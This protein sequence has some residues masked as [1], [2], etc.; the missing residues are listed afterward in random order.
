MFIEYV[1]KYIINQN[2]KNTKNK[3]DE[4]ILLGYMWLNILKGSG[5]W[6][7]IRK[8]ILGWPQ[9]KRICLSFSFLI[10][11]YIYVV[12]HEN[13]HLKRKEVWREITRSGLMNTSG[14]E[15]LIGYHRAHVCG[16]IPDHASY[17]CQSATH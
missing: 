8:N 5:S 6:I 13:F 14:Q 12:N 9:I 4:E 16:P 11:K 2:I 15:G 1:T 3:E 7:I 17:M 10:N